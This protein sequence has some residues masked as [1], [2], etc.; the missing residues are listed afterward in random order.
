MDVTNRIYVS[1]MA[2]DLIGS[3]ILKLANEVNHL[4]TQGRNIANYTV[5]DFNV[6]DFAIPKEL[7]DLIVEYYQQGQT[8]YPPAM[9]VLEL[10]RAVAKM[11]ETEL[12]VSYGTD[13]VLIAAGSRPLIFGIYSTILDPGDIVVYGVPSWNNNHYC[14][15]VGAYPQV[16]PTKP[17][18]NFMLTADDIR[19]YVGK[20]IL[21]AL[22]SPM[23]PTGTMF[24]AKDLREICEMV[25]EENETR[26]RRGAKPLYVMYDQVYWK[27]TF[28]HEHVHPLQFF[29]EMRDYTLYVDGISKYFAATGVRV[30]WT[31]GPK[32]VIAKMSNVLGHLGAWAPKPEQLAVAQYLGQTEAVARFVDDLKLTLIT[33]LKAVYERIQAL[34]A[35]GLP[36]DALEP[37]GG[38]YLSVYVGAAGKRTP[39]GKFLTTNEDICNYLLHHADTAIIPFQAFGDR[40]N[41]GWF[42]ISVGGVSD[43]DIETSMNNLQEALRALK[44]EHID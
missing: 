2:Y 21:L 23:N 27:L 7:T 16:A 29:P 3:E 32:P 17:E 18:H 44:V 9:G 40:D 4:K 41:Q 25:L 28:G 35:A 22:N 11:F 10:R 20:A 24:T 12:G 8:N 33:R 30:G 39:Q 19:P 31:C 14:H 1:L 34:K 5:G 43:D 15:I 37:Q 13:E 6:Q 26:V 36:V 38:I 42:R